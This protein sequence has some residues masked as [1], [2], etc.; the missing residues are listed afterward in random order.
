MKSLW[1]PGQE[2]LNTEAKECAS[3]HYQ[4]GYIFLK[5]FTLKLVYINMISSYSQTFLTIVLEQN[6]PPQN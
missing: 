4:N 2:N 6:A 5:C 3:R 1:H